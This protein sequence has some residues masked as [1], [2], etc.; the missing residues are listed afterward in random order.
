MGGWVK[1]ERA[2]MNDREAELQRE[3]LI[4]AI[5]YGCSAAD[6]RQRFGVSHH[7]VRQLRAEH[8]IPERPTRRSFLG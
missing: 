3:R 8:G 2:K 1:S 7:D 4:K 6:L 5:R